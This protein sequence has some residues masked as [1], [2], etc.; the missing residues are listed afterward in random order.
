MYEYLSQVKDPTLQKILKLLMD[1]VIGLNKQATAIGTVTQPLATTLDAAGNAITNVPTPA[2]TGDA[3][4]KDYADQ[5]YQ[6]LNKRVT[7]LGG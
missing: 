2:N 6:Q 5:L 7:K 1:H 4:N 3:V